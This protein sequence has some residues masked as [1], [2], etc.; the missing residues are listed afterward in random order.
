MKTT[1]RQPPFIKPLKI[2]SPRRA[3]TEI[4]AHVREMIVSGEIAP[5]TILSQADLS[6]ALGV[7]RTPVREALR[8]LQ[9]QG[10]V[11]AKTNHRAAVIGFDADA[12][13]ALYCKRLMLESLGVAHSVPRMSDADL[14]K[15]TRLLN[16]LNDDEC[17]VNFRAFARANRAFHLQLVMHGG[18][19]LINEIRESSERA[20]IYVSL[21]NKREG[22]NWWARPEIDHIELEAAFRARKVSWA[23]RLIAQHIARTAMVLLEAFVPDYEPV[24]LRTALQ[25]AMSAGN[26]IDAPVMPREAGRASVRVAPA[27]LS[28]GPAILA[29]KPKRAR[30]KPSKKRTNR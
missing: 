18:P 1:K 26:A 22:E 9:E 7:S 20:E 13:E 25:I 3:A 28:R 17:H 12:L 5:Q 6:Q 24:K 19:T 2:I 14:D 21:A 30:S 16:A 8:M 27:A 29:R 15:V 4:F 10:L 23:T 11:V